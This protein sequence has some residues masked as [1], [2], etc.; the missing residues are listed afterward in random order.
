MATVCGWGSEG[1]LAVVD[2]ATERDVPLSAGSSVAGV[3]GEGGSELIDGGFKV[4][5]PVAAC[6]PIGEIGR[7][8][9]ITGKLDMTV[10]H[11]ILKR[12]GP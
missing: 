2:V 9:P 10:L 7:R 4:E 12:P 6:E 1:S 8:L 5:P 11:A 3:A